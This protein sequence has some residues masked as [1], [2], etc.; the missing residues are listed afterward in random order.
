VAGKKQTQTPRYL[1]FVTTRDMVARVELDTAT[2][3][4]EAVAA[5]RA[6]ITSGKDIPPEVPN[7][8]R[9]LVWEKVRKQLP[10]GIK[11]VYICPDAD[12]CRVPFAAIPGDMPGTILLED[13][14]LA[15]IPHAPFLLDKLWP[16]DPIKNPPTAALV[17]GGVKY[18][19]E[20]AAP[21]PNPNTV[22]SRGDPLLKPGAKLGWS[23]LPGTTAEATGVSQAATTKKLTLNRLTGENATSEAVLAALPKAKVAHLA[24]HGFFADPSFRSAFQLNPKDYEQSLRGERIGGAARSPLVM[25]GLVLAGANNPKTPGRGIVTGEALVDLDLSGLE[26]VV[27]SACE[28]GVGDVAG[29][30]GT[31]GLQRAF[32]YAGTTNV[33]ASLWKVP[34]EPTAALMALF[35]RNLWNENLSPMESLRQA[36][37]EIYRNPGKIPDLAKGFRGKFEEV[38][39]AGEPVAQPSKEGKTHPLLWAAFSLSGSGR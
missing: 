1:A 24:T 33:I 16:Q 6:A 7:K 2:N 27:L 14:A 29:G 22:A 18:D 10:T 20:V 36:Q 19:A 28:T 23:F 15:T 38:A 30:E 5:W 13:F 9:E 17:V 21:S 4:E 25:T 37:L 34:D 31:F 32:H 26:L 11:T 39:G 8:V 3:V 35:Y 12:L